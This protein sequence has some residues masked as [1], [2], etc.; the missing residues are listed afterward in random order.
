MGLC[1]DA[2]LTWVMKIL[3]QAIPNTHMGHIW[4]LGCRFIVLSFCALLLFHSSSVP[5][6]N[7]CVNFKYFFCQNTC[8]FKTTAHT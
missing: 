7:E 4:P 6:F 5:H 8:H 2:M 3:M 1:F